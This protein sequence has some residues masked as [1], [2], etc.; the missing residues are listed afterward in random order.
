MNTINR[1]DSW[2][3][4]LVGMTII[5]GSAAPLKQDSM[6]VGTVTLYG[7]VPEPVIYGGTTCKGIRIAVSS[8]VPD[9]WLTLSVKWAS[10]A[11][12]KGW[13][14]GGLLKA[15]CG[16]TGNLD[17]HLERLNSYRNEYV[18]TMTLQERIVLAKK[19]LPYSDRFVFHRTPSKKDKVFLSWENSHAKT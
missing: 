2:G 11:I 15:V 5:R 19:S 7:G 10:D 9:D 8:Q 17:E 6:L 1:G 16:Y 4:P 18:A 12:H 13:R 3:L 14:S